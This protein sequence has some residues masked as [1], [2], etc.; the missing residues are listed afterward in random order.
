MTNHMRERARQHPRLREAIPADARTTLTY[1]AER[2]EITS[3]RDL[4]LQV[5]RLM[6]V[7]DAFFAL[8]C[9]R[10]KA[11]LQTLGVPVLPRLFHRLAMVSAQVCIGD[12]VIVAPGIYIAHGQVVIDGLVTVGSGTVL[13]P[14]ITVGLVAG[15]FQGPTI[16]ESVQ[17]GTGAKLLGPITIGNGATIG[18]NAVVVN[19]V[20]A[21]ATVVG[22]P[23]R[24]IRP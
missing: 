2:S 24:Q 22:V 13:L 4:I 5:L 7:T 23:A 16:G 8:V 17:I 1:R 6:W 11:R 9:Y 15:E 10:V 21:G 3:R 14:W 12:P 20:A 19:D 18:A